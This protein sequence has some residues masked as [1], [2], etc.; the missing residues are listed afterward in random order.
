MKEGGYIMEEIT[1]PVK[2]IRA[3]CLDCSCGNVFDV[4]KCTV[5]GCP[6]YPF[7]MGRNPYRKKRPLT[8]KQREVLSNYRKAAQ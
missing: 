4:S 6:L 3:K 2:A 7:R 1:N 8:D 5:Q